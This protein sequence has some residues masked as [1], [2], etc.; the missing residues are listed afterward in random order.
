MSETCGAVIALAIALAVFAGSWV[1]YIGLPNYR[2]RKVMREYAAH[3]A[4][5]RRP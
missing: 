1:R 2:V 3:R 4:G 5:R